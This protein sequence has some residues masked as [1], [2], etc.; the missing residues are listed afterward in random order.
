MSPFDLDFSLPLQ[1]PAAVN[2]IYRIQNPVCFKSEKFKF[3]AE[4]LI[5]RLKAISF[6]SAENHFLFSFGRA[7]SRSFGSRWLVVAFQDPEVLVQNTF[8]DW[9]SVQSL[10]THQERLWRSIGIHRDPMCKVEIRQ[11]RVSK[12]WVQQLHCNFGKPANYRKK[13]NNWLGNT[14]RRW[15]SW[16]SWKDEL[17]I[18]LSLRDLFAKAAGHSGPAVHRRA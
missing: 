16:W 8:S 14:V 1:H 7:F 12:F 10:W 15:P 4:K 13:T 3:K 6:C 17:T 18:W 2:P 9:I 5:R 11:W